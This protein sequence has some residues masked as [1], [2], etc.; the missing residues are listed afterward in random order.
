MKLQL[1]ISLLVS[2][3]MDTLKKSLDSISPLLREL[4]SELIIVFTGKNSA[5][6]ETARQYTSHIISFTWCDDFAKARN[7]G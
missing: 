2:D 3:R 6:L 1:T 4:N 7:A 5:V